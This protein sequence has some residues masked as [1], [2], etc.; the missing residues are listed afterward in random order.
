MFIFKHR[1]SWRMHKISDGFTIIE[2]IAAIIILG[3][4]ATLS[5]NM[6]RDYKIRQNVDSARQQFIN[7]VTVASASAAK[8]NVNYSVVYS[9][10]S[11][12]ILV[13]PTSSATTCSS[14]NAEYYS[15]LMMF[16]G[17]C[18]TLSDLNCI[19]IPSTSTE[20]TSNYLIVSP[21]GKVFTNME[22]G[23]FFVDNQKRVVDTQGSG[24]CLGVQIA[25]NGSV[26]TTE[27]A[28][29]SSGCASQG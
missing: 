15:N 18:P 1:S 8:F 10:A 21:F 19:D 11:H 25:V 22:Q 28:S 20:A 13:C 7:A 9:N 14:E 24:V 6:M 27:S 2:I 17:S 4:L 23:I 26:E 16:A 5:V 12:E 3:I 29:S